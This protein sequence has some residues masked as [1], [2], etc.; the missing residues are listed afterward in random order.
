MKTKITQRKSERANVLIVAICILGFA[1]LA[2]LTFL[3]LT[4]GENKAVARS[5]NWNASIPIVEAGIEEAM[6]HLNYDCAYSDITHQS[7]NNPWATQ[8]WNAI[9]IGYEKTTSLPNGAGY[10]VDIV[11]VAPFS[12]TN[13]AVV[14]QGHLA[15]LT[16]TIF[17]APFPFLAQI[18]TQTQ[19]GI[20]SSDVARKVQVNCG[21]QAIFAH[22]LVAK[23]S[24]DMHGNGVQT[25]SFDSSDPAYSTGGQYDPTKNKANGDIAV[26]SG[27]I[28]S[29]NLGNANIYGHAETG[30]GGSIALGPNGAVGDL[31]WQQSH[32][33][34]EPGYFSDDMNVYLPDVQVPFTGGYLTPG[35]GIST[36][37]ARNAAIVTNT[38]TTWPAGMDPITTNTVTVTTTSFP[39]AGTY[40]GTPNQNTTTTTTTTFP[41][42]GTYVG[43]VITNTANLSSSSF[44]TGYIGTPVTNTVVTTS[45]SYPT[46]GTYV[47]LV[48]TNTTSTISSSYPSAGTYLGAVTTNTTPASS[49]GYPGAG[50]YLGSVTTNC[51]T[52]VASDKNRPAVGTYCP[53]TPPW[54]GGNGNNNSS[55]W[56]WYPIS[57]YSYSKITGY[58]SSQITSYTYNQVSGYTYEGIASYTYSL[59]TGWTW[60]QIVSYTYYIYTTTTT[61]PTASSYDFLLGNGNYEIGTLSGDV[62]VTGNAVLYVTDDINTSSITIAPGATLKLYTSAPSVKLSG[63]GVWNQDGLATSFMYYGLPGNTSISLSG[64]AGFTGSIYAPEADFSLNGGGNNTTDFIGAAVVNSATLNGHFHFHYDE[65]LRKTG[66]T[67][68]FA[69]R[70]WNEIPLT[71][72]YTTVSE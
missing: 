7:G 5:Q 29:V 54:Q 30:P 20:G 46:A 22:G 61:A 51:S 58:T 66:P 48:L 13:P 24:I 6:A 42:A 28:N 14:S 62:L 43:A 34:I 25:D 11:T 23:N 64:N 16:G 67:A 38:V 19:T 32:S 39:S 57:G 56:N 55:A 26:V 8:G 52:S 36:N 63:N 4:D 70:T 47:G 59:I 18:G 33:G 72:R 21:S 60:A 49:G 53:S 10:T 31:A 1:G 35:P 44:P 68:A 27:L 37:A 41:T 12:R 9:D 50:S 2:L 40:L 3:N 71:Q 45:S 17:G 15:S 65:E 69:I